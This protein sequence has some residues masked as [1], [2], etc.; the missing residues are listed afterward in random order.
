MSQSIFWTYY[1]GFGTQFTCWM[2]EL[3]L[4]VLMEHVTRLGGNWID[5]FDILH[6]LITEFFKFEAD[7]IGLLLEGIGPKS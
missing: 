3:H 7:I 6:L 1:L 5:Q 2:E 4:I